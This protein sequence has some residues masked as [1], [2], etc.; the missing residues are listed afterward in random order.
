MNLNDK[1]WADKFEELYLKIE[2]LRAKS[3]RTL[4]EEQ[5]V[6]EVADIPT[7]YQFGILEALLASA[8]KHPKFPEG[9]IH[10]HEW[11]SNVKIEEIVGDLTKERFATTEE[12]NQW[13]EEHFSD[14]KPLA[15]GETFDVSRIAEYNGRLPDGL[16]IAP[17]GLVP[18]LDDVDKVREVLRGAHKEL[19][20]SAV[21]SDRLKLQPPSSMTPEVVEKLRLSNDPS[22]MRGWRLDS[23]SLGEHLQE[24]KGTWKFVEDSTSVAHSGEPP[25]PVFDW[26][27]EPTGKMLPEQCSMKA[28]EIRQRLDEVAMN[29]G[30]LK[31]GE[32]RKLNEEGAQSNGSERIAKQ[33]QPTQEAL[34]LEVI[35]TIVLQ[36]MKLP[37]YKRG[38]R[39]VKAEIWAVLRT[40]N[41][42]DFQSEKV[43][44]LA[45]SR[46]RRSK[47]IGSI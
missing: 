12:L 38:G 4:L 45:W 33:R 24:L 47:E 25:R 44:T 16:R 14:L 18:K 31:T 40:K 35:N 11:L 28:V 17:F 32:T 20:Y 1:S 21:N 10:F 30:G 26:K 46:L 34:I 3:L 9:S 22:L 39:N 42:A 15:L 43:F 19:L 5:P 29:D 36:P 37:R 7:G 13:N 2:P 41:T 8:H 27:V 23:A 6:Y